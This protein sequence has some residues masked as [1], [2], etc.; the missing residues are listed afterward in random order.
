M[1]FS[2]MIATRSMSAELV[3]QITGANVAYINQCR[4]GRDVNNTRRKELEAIR[5]TI[6]EARIKLEAARD[7]LETIRDDEQEAFDNMPESLQN[8]EKGEKSQESI[9]AME[10][11]YDELDSMATQCGDLDDVISTAKGE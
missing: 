8:G 4:K 10:T 2:E 7:A 3:A 1:T 6:A 5:E 9:D 11:I